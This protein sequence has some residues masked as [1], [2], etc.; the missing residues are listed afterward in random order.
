MRLILCR[1]CPGSGKSTFAAKKFPGVLHLENDMWHM[2]DGKY[3]FRGAMQPRAIAWC[4]TIANG[5][6]A[7]GMDVV[8]SNTFTKRRY[9]EAYRKLAEEHGAEFTV[10]RMHGE[11]GNVHSVPADVLEN[12][13]KNFEDWPGEIDVYP[14]GAGGE[15]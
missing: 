14:E 3:D 5:A 15:G 6:L 12:M 7:E 4:M 8:V 10:Y 9:I 2:K 1:G 11:F 13:R